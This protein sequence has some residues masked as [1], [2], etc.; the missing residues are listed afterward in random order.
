MA[1]RK[2]RQPEGAIPITK[3]WTWLAVALAAC[4]MLLG[5]AFYFDGIKF[6]RDIERTEMLLYAG[7]GIAGIV[8]VIF[9]ILV[10]ALKNDKRASRRPNRQ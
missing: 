4:A 8:G 9:P 1:K 5:G 3:L 2:S 7:W 6:F 10:K